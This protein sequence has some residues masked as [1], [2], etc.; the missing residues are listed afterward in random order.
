MSMAWRRSPATLLVGFGLLVGALIAPTVAGATAVQHGPGHFRGVVTASSRQGRAYRAQLQAR[1]VSGRSASASAGSAVNLLYWGGPVMHSDANYAIYWQPPGYSYSANYESLV[2]GFFTNVAA[3]SGALSNDYSVATQ[4]SDGS[5]PAAYSDSFAGSTVDTNPFPA[6]GCSAGSVCITDA[7]LQTEVQRVI[8]AQHLPTG[9]NRIYFVFFP[10]NV[11]TCFDSGGTQ[12]SSSVY[13]AYH[14]SIGSGPTGILYANMAYGDTSGCQSGENPESN[15]AADSVINIT[16]HE[17]I[18]TITDPLGSAWYDNSGNEIGDKCAWN[19]GTPLGG[20]TG[21][22]Y[23]EAIASGSY[24]LQQEWSNASSACAQ[25]LSAATSTPTAAYIFT[26]ASPQAGQAVSFSGASS[27]DT[28]ATITGYSWTFGDGATGTGV[29]PSHTYTN[30]GTYTVK[31]T[32]TDSAGHTSSV[33][34]TISVATAPASVPVA[35][36]T[37]LPSAPTHGQP[38]I[39]DGSSSTDTGASITGYSWSFGDGYG[40]S[41]IRPSHTYRRAGTYRV[42]LSIR[43]NRGKTASVAHT[44]TVK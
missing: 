1:H 6:S 21:A 37:Y 35:A 42:T 41:G 14:S 8:A 27:T 2:N 31:L 22:E 25:R 19:F 39:F 34:H 30:S 10:A 23:N 3:A 4:Y 7:Q 32:I 26:P 28:G 13:C 12:C 20:A 9:M 40:T 18:E 29:S 5:G 17:N 36:F 24:W 11:T 43:D 38:V 16:S 33:S 44:V 15:S